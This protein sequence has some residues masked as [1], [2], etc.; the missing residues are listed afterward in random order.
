MSESKTPLHV[1]ATNLGL[2][3]ALEVCQTCGTAQCPSQIESG[4]CFYCISRKLKAELA[5]MKQ[6]CESIGVIRDNQS[7]CIGDWMN[8]RD[9]IET[10]L[11]AE[12][13]RVAILDQENDR[14]N[15]ELTAS[16]A[17][18]QRLL[19]LV[20]LQRG[21]LHQKNAI[22]DEEYAALAA[23]VA[24]RSVLDTHD[25]LRGEIE[26]LEKQIQKCDKALAAS[27][28]REVQLRDAIKRIPEDRELPAHAWKAIIATESLPAPRVVPLA[29]A[30]KLADGFRR[31]KEIY[32]Q[33]TPAREV[34]HEALR[35]YEAWRSAK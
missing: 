6:K 2:S 13:K 22:S 12:R 24:S 8:Y 30:E 3:G 33:N 18:N 21:E 28:A 9:R 31:I 1:R 27:H 17:Q 32:S 29:L 16:H 11:A 14:L 5:A 25:T 15:E 10:E 4:E 26:V 35:E 20:R 34:A 19:S 7:R 23:D